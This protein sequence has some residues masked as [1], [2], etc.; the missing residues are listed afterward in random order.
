MASLHSVEAAGLSRPCSDK[1]GKQTV[2]VSAKLT[3]T[4]EEVLQ[5]AF[6]FLD[7]RGLSSLCLP[8]AHPPAPWTT[9]PLTL[10]TS[11]DR[12]GVRGVLELARTYC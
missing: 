1:V 11:S 9:C 3:W 7:K 12:A 4:A 5:K 10:L 2:T 6:Y 8:L